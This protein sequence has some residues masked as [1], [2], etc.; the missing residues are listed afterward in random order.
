MTD[1]SESQRRM[2]G[3]AYSAGSALTGPMFLG[4]FIDWLAG[5]LPWFLISG[6]VLGMFAVFVVL[7]KMTSPK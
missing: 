5:T 6:V 3:L 7:V 1:G 2:L 4:L